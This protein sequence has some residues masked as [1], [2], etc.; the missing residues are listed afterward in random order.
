MT[1]RSFV[2][3]C[4]AI[5]VYCILQTA[6]FA[7]SQATLPALQRLKGAASTVRLAY[8]ERSDFAP[9][10]KLLIDGK[11]ERILAAIAELEAISPRLSNNDRAVFDVA[12]ADIA[13]FLLSQ[14]DAAVPQVSSNLDVI[15]IDL[16]AKAAPRVGM[17]A[18]LK[19]SRMVAVEVRVITVRNGAKVQVPGLAIGAVTL[20]KQDRGC[21]EKRFGQLS[22]PS[23]ER[24]F[25]GAYRFCA[26]DHNRLVGKADW[27][28]VGGDGRP[29]KIVEIAVP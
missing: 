5:M 7:Q 12:I 24:L 10:A 25:S 16:Q 14:K 20:A 1:K 4:V 11:V 29:D 26:F 18:Y 27:I 23:V 2:H 22:S 17:G 15:L 19:P 28:A 9:D 8:A 6:S 21:L 13:T 3:F